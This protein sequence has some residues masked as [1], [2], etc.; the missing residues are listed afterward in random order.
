MTNLAEVL[1]NYLFPRH[2]SNHPHSVALN[3][4]LEVDAMRTIITAGALL[5][6]AACTPDP[7][8]NATGGA[9]GGAAVGCGIGAA[10]TAPLLGVGCVPGAI[11]GG[12]AGSG[13]GLASTPP[14]PSPPSTAYAY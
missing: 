10:V 11:I 5:A 7:G 14:P 3:L 13:A 2:R 8:A 9:L 4:G 1:V 6:L 12:A